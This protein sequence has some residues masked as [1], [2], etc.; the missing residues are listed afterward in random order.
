MA[1]T[2]IGLAFFAGMLP[3]GT[4]EMVKEDLSLEQVQEAIR[5][6]VV[7]CFNPSHT[8]SIDALREKHGIEVEIPETPTRISLES[9]NAIIVLQ[10]RGL[11]RLSDERR[12]QYNSPGE[13]TPEEVNSA[14]F[15]FMKIAVR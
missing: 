2:Y 14:S 15:S 6:G 3:A 1:T 10:I 11:L 7:S 8:A 12:E 4:V 5:Q 9:G 13:Y